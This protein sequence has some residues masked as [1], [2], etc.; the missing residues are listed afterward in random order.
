MGKIK[1]HLPQKETDF[2]LWFFKYKLSEFFLGII[3][4]DKNGNNSIKEKNAN[5]YK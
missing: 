3:Q 5:L 1:T 4:K 2:C